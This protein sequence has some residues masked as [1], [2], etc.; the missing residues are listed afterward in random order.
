MGEMQGRGWPTDRPGSL[1]G[2]T[3]GS[4]RRV[5]GGR[6]TDRVGTRR[7][8]IGPNIKLR[9]FETGACERVASVGARGLASV[10][11]RY[12]FAWRRGTRACSALLLL[13]LDQMR[14]RTGFCGAAIVLLVANILVASVTFMDG[15]LRA[16]PRNLTTPEEVFMIMGQN[17][18]KYRAPCAYVGRPPGRLLQRP[19]PAAL[20]DVKFKINFAPP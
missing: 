7:V 2:R 3:A 16:P 10:E 4:S 19:S 18:E 15:S 20:R 11:S 17:L 5:G 6:P 14:A 13:N 12:L 8:Y 9:S 1:V